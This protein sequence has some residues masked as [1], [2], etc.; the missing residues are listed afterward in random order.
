[1]PDPADTWAALT[2]PSDG[3]TARL[4]PGSGDVWLALD[5]NGRRHLLVRA[6]SAEPN[7]TL[8][9]TRG[10][11]AM[12]AVLSVEQEAEDVWTDIACL[13]PAFNET[14]VTVADNLA[15]EVRAN[16]N[17]PLDA[18][19]LTLR[20]WQWFWGI[21]PASLSG[22]KAIGL[23]GELWFIDRW[24]PFPEVI[25]TWFGPTGHRHD[26]TALAV[27][28][29]VKATLVRSD[30]PARHRIT[31]LDQ[32]APPES[33][34]LY[35]FS[36]QAIRDPNA[37]NT[38]PGLIARVRGRLASRPDLIGLLDQRL[39]QAGWSPAHADLHTQPYRIVAEE[40][41]HIDDG[42]PRLVR[43]SFVGGVPAGV[44]D[45]IYTLDL[46][47]C[48]SWRVSVHPAQAKHILAGLTS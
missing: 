30:G 36:L 11:R 13:D 19:R 46:A 28:V 43:S 27:S 10:L 15:E 31:S 5:S 25:D 1:M 18:V 24:A 23:F 47:A 38:L 12:T 9:A 41:Y 8:M 6:T 35:L 17:D 48:S 16:P 3:L 44:D 2:R 34:S 42:F 22:E 32:L 26:F 40:L 33:G 14:F 4:H 39:G 45:I 29:E 20:R 7:Q 21:D 37:G